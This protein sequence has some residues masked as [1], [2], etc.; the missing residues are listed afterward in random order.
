MGLRG[1]IRWRWPPQAM[2]IYHIR[3]ATCSNGSRFQKPNMKVEVAGLLA[4]GSPVSI[5]PDVNVS[6]QYFVRH[7]REEDAQ[8]QRT[9]C[10]TIGIV[11]SQLDPHSSL[12][13]LRTASPPTCAADHASPRRARPWPDTTAYW[14]CHGWKSE[15]CAC[16][17]A[18]CSEGSS[19]RIRVVE[20][21]E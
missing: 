3:H 6:S 11:I 17:W 21:S 10:N 18:A 5:E 2:I 4:A 14:L 20:T 1:N 16:P 7:A 12:P 19:A 15:V 13:G 9:S 8:A